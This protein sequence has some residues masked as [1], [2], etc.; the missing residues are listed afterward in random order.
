VKHRTHLDIW[1]LN[2]PTIP[3]LNG[4]GLPPSI[5]R[6]ALGCS[7]ACRIQL[8][9]G[10]SRDYFH[11]IALTNDG[12]LLAA[13]GGGAQES[14]SL[15]AL[16]GLR[17]WHLTRSARD[18]EIVAVK[19]Q[20]SESILELFAEDLTCQ[21]LAFSSDGRSLC[22]T[23]SGS[24]SVKLVL[25]DVEKPNKKNNNQYEI[26]IRHIINHTKQITARR[27]RGAGGAD[28]SS[29]SG[30][31][32]LSNNERLSSAISSLTYS[33]DGQWLGVCSCDKLVFIYEMDRLSL[34]WEI[35]SFESSVS[36]L[37]FHPQSPNSLVVVL[38]GDNSFQIFDVQDKTLSPWS[39]ENKDLI[40]SWASSLGKAA[41]GPVMNIAFDPTCVSAFVLHGQAFSIYVN[42]DRPLPSPTDNHQPATN[43]F[44][45]FS[46]Q[47]EV[48]TQSMLSSAASA[49]GAPSKLDLIQK[50]LQELVPT[51]RKY[52][53]KR[54]QLQKLLDEETKLTSAAA[55]AEEVA[56]K[57][58]KKTRM[59]S[60]AAVVQANEMRN[61][62]LLKSHRSIVYLSVLNSNEM[63]SSSSPSVS[64][65]LSLSLSLLLSHLTP[66]TLSLCRS[67]WRTH[68]CECWRIFLRLWLGKDMARKVRDSEVRGLRA[69]AI[70][71]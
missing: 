65:S 49:T 36:C 25:L 32:A 21:A 23:L 40:P 37:A 43:S 39:L 30:S 68:G 4:K 62:S 13:T 11:S 29:G 41:S 48:V 51:D 45:E 59:S 55:D 60:A 42:L 56:S 31:N 34:H 6:T 67:S 8:K 1:S 58:S 14:D 7:L 5:D 24:D 12:E 28:S 61:F 35:P 69:I 71:V 63:V 22:V 15:D 26:T 17:L 19:V 47:V 18:S 50:E 64:L 16:S 44:T 52:L 20:L 38:S 10:V 70:G 66:L 33:A 27:Q 53:K 54:K 46:P 2:H 9:D 57:K 3:T